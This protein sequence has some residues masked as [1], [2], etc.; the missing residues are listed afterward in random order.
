MIELREGSATLD[1]SAYRSFVKEF[2][3]SVELAGKTQKNL[4]V[5]CSRKILHGGR[6]DH[7]MMLQTLRE[8]GLTGQPPWILSEEELM[9]GG[10]EHMTQKPNTS[11]PL[12]I[13]KSSCDIIDSSV[14]WMDPA[15]KIY[16]IAPQT[17]ISAVVAEKLT[18]NKSK[19][20][21]PYYQFHSPESGKVIYFVSPGRIH[22]LVIYT[23]ENGE[24]IEGKISTI[25]G[26]IKREEFKKHFRGVLS[27]VHPSTVFR[28]PINIGKERMNALKVLFKIHYE[29]S[30]D[31]AKDF[32][33]KEIAER[34][35]LEWVHRV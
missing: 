19:E 20:A 6:R 15:D 7:D 12:S 24:I 9:N 13:L 25:I 21:I 29:G 27:F 3:A 22:Y 2:Y 33:S 1:Q 34:L 35:G 5:D 4:L 17:I 26:D 10:S 11:L 32:S 31:Y 28:V 23:A 18:K 30:Y 16:E 8:R 14:I